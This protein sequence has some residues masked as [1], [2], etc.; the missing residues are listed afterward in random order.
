MKAVEN[1]GF[2]AYD[3]PFPSERER[4]GVSVVQT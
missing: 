3:I 4:G 1:L 2:C